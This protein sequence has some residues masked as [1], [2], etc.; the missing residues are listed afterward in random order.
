VY[1]HIGI[2]L[3]IIDDN[4]SSESNTGGFYIFQA[5]VRK[6]GFCCSNVEEQEHVP[7]EVANLAAFYFYQTKFLSQG[8][9][10]N[11]IRLTIR[12]I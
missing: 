11:L 5:V 6:N 4:L 12:D 7:I 9:D 3:G 10:K 8:K 1:W 2:E